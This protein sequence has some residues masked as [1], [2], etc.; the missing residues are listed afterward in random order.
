MKKSFA[1]KF[2]FIIA[3]WF[4]ISLAIPVTDVLGYRS[5]GLLLR[6]LL[7]AGTLLVFLF[8]AAR[9]LFLLLAA[10]AVFFPA[11]AAYLLA[12]LSF[13]QFL[14]RF[15]QAAVNNNTVRLAAV[16]AV[17][18]LFCLLLVKCRKKLPLLLLGGI[19][20][21]VP[22]W[23]LY[24]DSAYPAAVS[25][26]LCWL[27]LLSH[28]N[29][30]R[31]WSGIQGESPDKFRR[32]WL[33]YTVKIIAGVLLVALLL[34]KSIPPVQWK[35]LE[36]MA[37]SAFPFLTELR[38]GKG[39][40]TQ[41]RSNEFTLA[42]A[43]YGE[44]ACLGGPIL[45]NPD[46]LLE[47]KGDG[48]LYLRGS[49][50]ASYTGY[51]WIDSGETVKWRPFPP[52]QDGSLRRYLKAVSLSVNHRNLPVS[53]VFTLQ[54]TTEIKGFLADAELYLTAGNGVISP[55]AASAGNWY[56]LR[57][58][59]LGYSGDFAS[60][61][62]REE[63]AFASGSIWLSLPGGLPA[64]VRELAAEI[65]ENAEG[66]YAKM[67]ALTA[68]LRGTYPYAEDP[69]PLP[70]K[71]DFVDFF[72]FEEKKGYCTYFATALA[73]MAR[74]V[75]IPTRYVQGFIIP[76]TADADG[77]YRLTGSS[78]HAWVEA[79]I[80]GLGWLPFE[81]TPRYPAMDTLPY[82]ETVSPPAETQAPPQV[83]PPP[84]P[85]PGESIIPQ[86]REKRELP[87]FYRR[88]VLAASFL[89]ILLAAAAF[90]VLV[91]RRKRRLQEYF[92]RLEELPAAQKAVAYYNLALGLLPAL[93]LSK[94]PGETPREYSARINRHL[95]NWQLDFK[96][97]S[98]GINI[99]LYSKSGKAPE[100]LAEKTKAF[101]EN[102][103]A[104]YLT[105]AGRQ[106]AFV[107]LYIRQKY[108]TEIL[109]R[110]LLN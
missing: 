16:T 77:I 71:L 40:G 49:V 89:L 74:T 26:A 42:I 107:E 32:T 100:G 103:Y 33:Y 88:L 59:T 38:G 62:N 69:A 14:Q 30:N 28:E 44:R 52:P 86:A 109:F 17:I 95:F 76:E 6:L 13:L 92:A 25:Y 98:E 15:L 54:Y 64:R 46:V 41:K 78:A 102:I 110:T 22:L 36:D 39:S 66:H 21:F 84:V 12:P 11:V 5:A 8:F 58:M 29:G 53:T 93:E 4:S 9:P 63:P 31:I 10:A 20:I 60:L 99:V 27:L 19:F 70:E 37:V 82:R 101:F 1:G 90:T 23:Y 80:P 96:D 24:I 75:G 34:P 43:G 81:A 7:T 67:Q 105:A 2:A 61:E 87:V 68:Y 47:V 56:G 50:K 85:T 73:V 97:I 48:G 3:C 104:R 51:S 94:S 65:T 45:K 72:L 106:K 108:L 83:L 18:T 91:W 57:G 55:S 35:A 79:Y